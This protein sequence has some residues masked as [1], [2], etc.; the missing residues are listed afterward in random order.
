MLMI[1]PP[2]YTINTNSKKP[3]INLDLICCEEQLFYGLLRLKNLDYHIRDSE[4]RLIDFIYGR[5]A[6]EK[7]IELNAELII[8]KE[9]KTNTKIDF[10]KN[11]KENKEKICKFYS[12]HSNLDDI[13]IKQTILEKINLSFLR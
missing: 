1:S 7:S 3:N 10:D 2:N 12:V 11:F 8:D 9:S 4:K 13:L 5:H 6:H